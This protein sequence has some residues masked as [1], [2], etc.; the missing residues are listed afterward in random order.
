ML[1]PPFTQEQLDALLETDP[2]YGQ[3][4]VVA[5]IN[6]GRLCVGRL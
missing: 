3:F 5:A 1:K 2:K 4:D 6:M